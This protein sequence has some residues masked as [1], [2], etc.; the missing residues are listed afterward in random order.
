[1]LPIKMVSTTVEI[2]S[3]VGGWVFRYTQ[4]K[5]W[6]IPEADCV[7]TLSIGGHFWHFSRT[8]YWKPG[9]DYFNAILT[10]RGIDIED[11]ITC[12]KLFHALRQDGSWYCL[13][14]EIEASLLF[15][16]QQFHPV[17]S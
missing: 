16:L 13:D 9:G 2:H 4:G 11:H 3:F 17:G 5:I 15:Q 10:L 7:I 1:M 14:K 8:L 12:S 6:E